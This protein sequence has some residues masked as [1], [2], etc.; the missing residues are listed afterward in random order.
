MAETDI[1]VHKTAYKPTAGER[2]FILHGFYNDDGELILEL[3]TNIGKV[4]NR[5][6]R[7]GW[8]LKEVQYHH[9]GSWVSSVWTA[10]YK[11]ISIRQA[12]PQKRTMTD[13]QRKAAAERLKKSRE[14]K[15]S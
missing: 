8:K 13:E 2:E 1:I 5:C 4:N 3:D 15:E 9:D 14:R 10:P 6:E 7:A 12:E 11:A